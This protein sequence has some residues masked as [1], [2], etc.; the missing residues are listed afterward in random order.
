MGTVILT[1]LTF[2]ITDDIK[3]RL[4]LDYRGRRG[5]AIGFESDIDY[6]KDKSS[7]A[8][9]KT[10][11]LQDQNPLIN[12]TNLPRK[13]VPTGRYRFSLEDRTDFTDDIYAHRRRNKAKRPIRVCR[14]FTKTNSGSNPVPDNVIAV[15]ENR[16]VLHFDCD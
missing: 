13:D 1:Q 10:Y 14:T 16:P 9:L 5:L 11:Y 6:G 3:G 4:R 8:K 7:W 2:P 15:T 12:Q